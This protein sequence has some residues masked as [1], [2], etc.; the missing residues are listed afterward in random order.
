MQAKETPSPEQWT[1]LKRIMDRCC[2]E[3]SELLSPGV[4]AARSSK[5]LSEPVRDCLFGIPGA[6]ESSCLKWVRSYFEECLA[7]EDGIQFVFLASQNTMAALTG[8]QTVHSW[9]KIP[10]NATDAASKGLHSKTDGDVDVLFLNALGIRWFLVDECTTLSPGIMGLLDA[11]LR[12]AYA[13]HRYGGRGHAQRPF[14]GIN[15]VFC[16]DLG[17]LPPA[18][19]A[20]IFPN[21]FKARYSCEEQKMFKMFWCRGDD[22]IQKT[23]E[24]TAPF[25]SK[26][27]WLNEVLAA[28]RYGRET[29]EMYCF[30]HGLPTRNTG[31]WLPSANGP[32]CGVAR[33]RQLSSE[34]WGT[35]WQRMRGM[36]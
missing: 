34:M 1:F 23:F 8:G 2:P 20:A 28:D 17:Q 35:M 26:D 19:A 21:P 31:S 27:M 15:V 3:R 10:I 13:R 7:W 9:G 18:K 11:F 32:T 36:Q 16:G 14:G 33:C 22:S 25:R 24:L 5:K 30:I 29:W 6:G 4:R 12:R